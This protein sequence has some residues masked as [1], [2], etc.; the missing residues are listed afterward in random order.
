[1]AESKSTLPDMVAKVYRD[2][3][4]FVPQLKDQTGY[5]DLETQELVYRRLGR[6]PAS[7]QEKALEYLLSLVK[8]SI[9]NSAD[10]TSVSYD[11]GRIQVFECNAPRAALIAGALDPGC[12]LISD[13]TMDDSEMA[14]ARAYWK[15]KKHLV[16]YTKTTISAWAETNFEDSKD[17]TNDKAFDKFI[18]T[19]RSK[20]RDALQS[21]C[22][23]PTM[24]EIEDRLRVW[25]VD[26]IPMG[27][28]G[29]ADTSGANASSSNGAGDPRH[30][31]LN[32]T[33][34]DRGTEDNNG[35]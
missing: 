11:S 20:V 6:N 14:E 18:V 29:T 19:L 34:Q 24:M 2:M 16:K 1:M 15:T 9:K 31:A 26:A 13:D 28:L 23:T 17:I 21:R 30:V 32:Q 35:E 3:V 33:S 10:Q 22:V 12:Q 5:Y 7:R 4:A 27:P 8:L 25:V